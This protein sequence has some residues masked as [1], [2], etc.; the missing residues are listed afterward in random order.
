[1]A[2]KPQVFIC[3]MSPTFSG[4]RWFEAGMRE[5]FKEIQ[6]K[7]EEISKKSS[8]GLIDLHKPL[9]LFPEFFPDNLHPT[10]EGAAIIAKKTYSAITGDFGGLQ[11]PALYGEKMVLQRNKPITISG[12]ANANDE[13]NVVFNKVS[14]TTKVLANGKWKITFPSMEA[15]GPYKLSIRSAYSENITI[16]K[17]YIG[18]VWLAS[19]QSNMDFKVKSM[20]NAQSVLQDSLSSNIFLFSMDG[21]VGSNREFSKDEL[22]NCNALNYFK[23][24]GWDNNKTEVL[25]NFSAVAYAFAY[26]LLKELKIPIGII[27]NAVGGS[28]T[29]SWISRESMEKSH[30]TIDLLNNTHSNPMIHPWVLGRMAKNLKNQ[31]K[32]GIKVRHQFE[33]TMLYDAG[34]HPLKN[35][36]IKGVIWYQGESNAERVDFHSML[37][38]LLVD[39]WRMHWDNP[40][41]PFYSVQLSSINRP[42]WGHFRDA[43]RKLLL[44][45][46]TGMAVSSD[47]GHPTNVHPK[48]KWIVGAR[49]SYIAL[50]KTYNKNIPYSG[51]LFDYVNITDGKMEVHF[52]FGEGLT[53]TNNEIVKDI[54]I[55]GA[56]RNFVKAQ[57]KIE[58]N[59]LQVWSAEIKSPRYLKYGY[60]PFTTGNLVNKYGLPTSTFSN[61]NE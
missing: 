5:Y 26:N 10:K 60:S 56:D 49:L 1:M 21:N 46:N 20:E 27:C 58:N 24:S 34:I 14:Q 53:T 23:Y 29:Q 9:Y 50:S 47:V 38:K 12:I 22:L 13:I 51:P 61:L 15:G 17:V 37:F 16:N 6:I 11:L 3:R 25:E 31:K 42:T 32:L 55:A 54:L 59:I 33:P 36:N 30:E 41:L 35:Y 57:S 43:Q 18:E 4:H 39:D 8:V 7:I 45:P 19:G 2:S 40:E 52:Q 48:K 44:I 28:T